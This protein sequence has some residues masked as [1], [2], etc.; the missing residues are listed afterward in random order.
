MFIF[1]KCNPPIF[2]LIWNGLSKSWWS[3]KIIFYIGQILAL[4]RPPSPIFKATRRT[5]CSTYEH[6][7]ML[8]FIIFFFLMFSWQKKCPL[9]VEVKHMSQSLLIFFLFL[10][11]FSFWSNLSSVSH[12]IMFILRSPILLKS[13]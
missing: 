7:H 8:H 2:A 3:K 9:G 1:G 11:L 4:A 13:F 5:F 12:S 6:Q 10:F